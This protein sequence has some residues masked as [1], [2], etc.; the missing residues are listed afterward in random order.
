MLATPPSPAVSGQA[1]APA[2]ANG[3]T[4]QPLTERTVSQGGRARDPARGPQS[5]VTQTAPA[6]TATSWGVPPTLIVATTRFELGSIRA[7][8]PSPL[9]TQTDPAPTATPAGCWPTVTLCSTRLVL[10]SIRQT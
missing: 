8:V 2:S 9:A 4:H 5:T 10:G 3:T 7:T 1:S 6:Q